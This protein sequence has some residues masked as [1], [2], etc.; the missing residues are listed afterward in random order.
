MK[1][2]VTSWTPRNADGYRTE[3]ANFRSVTYPSARAATDARRKEA[4]KGRV[5]CAR[6]KAG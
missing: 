3:N 4:R 6:R 2:T 5:T 1:I